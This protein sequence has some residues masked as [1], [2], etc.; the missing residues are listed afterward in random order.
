M[1]LFDK[2]IGHGRTAR[3]RILNLLK[4][5]PNIIIIKKIPLQKILYNLIVSTIT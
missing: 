5:I 4:K 1:N 3:Q 2:K